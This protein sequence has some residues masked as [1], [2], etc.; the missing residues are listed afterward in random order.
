[1]TVMNLKNV[2]VPLF[3]G[4]LWTLAGYM[5]AGSGLLRPHPRGQQREPFFEGVTKN[6]L[7]KY[8]RQLLSDRG[9]DRW[10][11]VQTKEG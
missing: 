2:W 11:I 5:A 9:I 10:R 8:P 7:P 1:M 4:L 6:P 3:N